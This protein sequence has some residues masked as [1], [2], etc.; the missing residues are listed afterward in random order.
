MTLHQAAGLPAHLWQ[1][2]RRQ[3]ECARQARRLLP[4]EPG[5]GLNKMQ[6]MQATPSSSACRALEGR[7]TLFWHAMEW[8]GVEACCID[9]QT[10]L[11]THGISLHTLSMLQY[12]QR[13]TRQSQ[14]HACCLKID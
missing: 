2:Q 1:P 14:E 5:D 11:Y 13:L 9:D 6:D 3:G 4:G 7:A 12:T 8:D 10:W